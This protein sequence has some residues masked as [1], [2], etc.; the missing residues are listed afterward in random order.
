MDELIK[1]ELAAQVLHESIP[2][3][4]RDQWALWLQNNRNPRRRA[5]YRIPFE[6]IGISVFYRRDELSKYSEWEKQ[7]QLGTI[8]LTGRAAEVMRAYG[9][10]EAG[11][12]ATGR[13]FNVSAIDLQTDPVSEKPYIALILEDP[14]MVFRLEIEEAIHHAN[15]LIELA[16]ATERIANES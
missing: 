7:R 2:V 15:K 10:G 13:K 12:G 5:T 6:R 3:R 11:G 9:I 1:S 8:K 14:L 16:K 4:S